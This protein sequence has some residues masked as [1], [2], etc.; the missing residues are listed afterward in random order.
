MEQRQ[1]SAID[2]RSKLLKN[3]E[4][5]DILKISQLAFH[6]NKLAVLENVSIYYGEIIIASRGV[7]SI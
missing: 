3:I 1:Q 5:S 7:L 6:K 4:S 2:E